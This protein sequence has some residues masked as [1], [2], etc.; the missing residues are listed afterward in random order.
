MNYVVRVFYWHFGV[1]SEQDFSADHQRHIGFLMVAEIRSTSGVGQHIHPDCSHSHS[2][3][4]RANFE[5]WILTYS[6]LIFLKRITHFMF[7]FFFA[8]WRVLDSHH[9][10]PW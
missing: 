6:N 7:I 3:C 10:K 4:C 8:C 9:A 1:K 2:G 5:V